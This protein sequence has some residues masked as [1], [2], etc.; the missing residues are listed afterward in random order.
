MLKVDQDTATGMMV[1]LGYPNAKKW[2][3]ARLAFLES[4]EHGPKIN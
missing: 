4:P 2:P 1:A 3:E